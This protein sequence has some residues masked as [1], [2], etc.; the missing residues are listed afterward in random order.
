M[1]I[2]AIETSCDETAAAILKCSG[3]LKNPR[4]EILSNVV[5]SQVKIHSQWGGVVPSLAKRE[6]QKNLIPILIRTLKKAS[7]LNSKS[8]ARN[9]RPAFGGARFAREARRARLVPMDIGTAKFKILNSILKREPE[10][11][12]KLLK[13]LREHQEPKIDVIAVTQGPG[14][15]PALWVGIN[16]AKALAI[17][18]DKP[19]IAIN[20]MEGHFFSAFLKK[21]FPPRQRRGGNFVLRIS[22]FGFRCFC[23]NGWPSRI[24][25]PQHSRHFIKGFA[26]RVIQ[27]FSDDFIFSPSASW[28]IY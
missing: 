7:L 17:V 14:L 12:E 24:S 10:L 15:E 3:K 1:I 27:S 8:E 6:H 18:W 16:F 2:L 21:D 13:F 19:L 20:H 26:G 22:N 4:F 25:Q 11:L 28:R 23:S 5:A 9:S